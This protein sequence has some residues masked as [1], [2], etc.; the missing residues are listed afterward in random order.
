MTNA[1]KI[2]ADLRTG[3]PLTDEALR[4]RTGVEPH[5]QVNQICRRLEAQGL[6]H[7]D[8]GNRVDIY[9]S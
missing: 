4:K 5:Q 3:G 9:V 1:E 2:L 8:L 7:G 6:I